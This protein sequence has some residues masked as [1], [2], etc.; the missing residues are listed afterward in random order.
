MADCPYCKKTFSLSSKAE[1][2]VRVL[3]P[4]KLVHIQ[5]PKCSGMISIDRN[6]RTA[7]AKKKADVAAVKPSSTKKKPPKKERIMPPAPPDI[8][9]LKKGSG[10]EEESANDDEA[11][12]AMVLVREEQG[13]AQVVAAIESMG[14]RVDI[15]DSSEEAFD[16]IAFGSYAMIALHSRFEGSGINTNS[17]HL[18]MRMQRMVSRRYIFYFL[19]GPEF[20]TL[21]E[22]QAMV[23]SA[24]LVINDNELPH[25]ASI[26]AKK[27]PEYDRLFGQI[28]EEIRIQGKLI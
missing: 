7:K 17:F 20:Q 24:N 8:S 4:D 5:C 11:T 18:H 16:K 3:S 2:S 22:L 15:V 19:I 23:F 28:I 26:L 9:W 12:L 6:F 25:L 10:D 13:R 14:Y 1:S 21:Y 27:I